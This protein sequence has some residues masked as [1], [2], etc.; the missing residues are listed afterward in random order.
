M[1]DLESTTKQP[2]GSRGSRLARF[3]NKLSLHQRSK[4]SEP[5]LHRRDNRN[6]AATGHEQQHKQTTTDVSTSGPSTKFKETPHPTQASN[7]DSLC[8]I[9][10]L[11]NDAYDELRGQEENLM[12]DYEATL[13]SDLATMVGSTVILSGSNV[14]KNSQMMN[15][16]SRKVEEVK[17]NT[18]KLRFGGHDVQLKDLAQPVVSIIQ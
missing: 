17:K 15:L 8:P 13:C 7:T 6:E 9:H 11:W 5:S 2:K 4:D 18:W 10:E 3:K 16:L 1:S 12:K 14:E